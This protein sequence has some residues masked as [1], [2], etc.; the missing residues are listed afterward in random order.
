MPDLRTY[1][2]DN[3]KKLRCVLSPLN[4]QRGGRIVNSINYKVLEKN[5]NL[6]RFCI[7]PYG[8][9]FMSRDAKAN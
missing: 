8:N 2:N 5:R 4:T 7:E 1:I 9:L 3:H 6:F